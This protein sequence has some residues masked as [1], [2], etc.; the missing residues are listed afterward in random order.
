MGDKWDTCSNSQEYVSQYQLSKLE[1][2]LMAKLEDVKVAA[3]EE[4]AQVAEAIATLEAKVKALQ[5]QIGSGEVVTP[6]QL[7]DVVNEVKGIFNPPVV[8]G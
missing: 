3:A 5:D 8:E 2:K 4:K 7:D 1:N 6:E